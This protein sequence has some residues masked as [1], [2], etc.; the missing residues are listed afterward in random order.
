MSYA[1]KKSA[2]AAAK[3]SH[4]ANWSET[5]AVELVDGKWVILEVETVGGD[6][7]EFTEETDVPAVPGI[8]SCLLQN[9]AGAPVPEV[10]AVPAP[11]VPE[12]KGLVIEQNRP[13]QNGVTRP[14]AGGACRAVWDFCW[15]VGP[16]IP[17]VAQV[18]SH[19][20]KMG[21]NV[22]NAS[23]EYYCW[24]KYNGISGRVAVTAAPAP[25]P[26]APV[27]VE[28]GESALAALGF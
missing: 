10:P 8:L 16:A 23:F 13:K 4:G 11:Q 24:R 5:H 20:V 26:V 15:S 27:T 22:N 17:T 19:A 2:S 7:D 6:R 28:E 12:H 25:A 14:S 9:M 18:K 1:T 3:K 21:W